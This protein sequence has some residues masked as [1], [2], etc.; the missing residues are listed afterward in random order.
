MIERTCGPQHARIGRGARRRPPS[1]PCRREAPS[2]RNCCRALAPPAAIASGPRHADAIEAVL[3]CAS[4]S[5]ALSSAASSEVQIGVG[6]RR[7]E[8]R[9]GLGQQRAERRAATSPARTSPWRPRLRSTAHR[10][11]NRPPTGAP[12]RPD[13]HRSA[14]RRR[15]S[16]GCAPASRYRPDDSGCCGAPHGSPRCPASR[17]PLERH[18]ALVARARWSSGPLTS[19]KN[20]S[21][22][23]LISRRTSTRGRRHRCGSSRRSPS[24][25]AAGLVEIFRD[26]GGARN[27][28]A[29]LGHQDRASCRPG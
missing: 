26:D 1:S 3:A 16:R 18:A 2:A 21:L 7:R 10:P 11:D 19:A 20:L 29:A 27:R 25:L 4:T 5:A 8:S 6:R 28:R 13:P 23:Q 9:P 22:N 17:R 14:G 15:A 24:S 12:P